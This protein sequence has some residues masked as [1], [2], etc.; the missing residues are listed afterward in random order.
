VAIELRKQGKT[1][2]EV[3]AIVGVHPRTVDEW[4]S[5]ISNFKNENAN[6]PDLRYKIP[7]GAQEEI[8][9]RYK[10]GESQ[11]KLA[12]EFKISQGRVSQIVKKIEREKERAAKEA[13]EVKRAEFL[14]SLRSAPCLAAI[15][16]ILPAVPLSSASSR[17]L[18][19]I[20]SPIAQTFA[21]FRFPTFLTSLCLS[22]LLSC[23]LTVSEHTF[24]HLAISAGVDGPSSNKAASTP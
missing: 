16:H 20:I 6:T 1:Q 8:Y 24:N 5:D 3:A 7:K 18:T 4:E 2:A 9:K 10:S 11:K 12:V 13:E 23:F 19:V 14:N 21:L 17:S 22:S 15:S